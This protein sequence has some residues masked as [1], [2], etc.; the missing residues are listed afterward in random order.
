MAQGALEAQ[1][2]QEGGEAQGAQLPWL[3]YSSPAAGD[4]A[5]S[6]LGG[7]GGQGTVGLGG[8][9][10]VQLTRPGPWLGLGPA[11]DLA[12]EREPASAHGPWVGPEA[13][14]GPGAVGGRGAQPRSPDSGSGA[15]TVPEP[16]VRSPA[17]F[18]SS[19]H[20][21]PSPR[22]VVP[23]PP[24]A[25]SAPHA[26][27]APPV[28]GAGAGRGSGAALPIPHSLTTPQRLLPP[29]APPAWQ[30]QGRAGYLLAPAALP[31]EGWPRGVHLVMPSQ[32]NGG[33]QAGY[34]YGYGCGRPQTLPVPAAVG[35]PRAVRVV[36]APPA[37]SVPAPALN[38]TPVG[39]E[40][41][42]D[43]LLELCM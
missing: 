31:Q 9:G 13:G 21:S 6:S 29:Q 38:P 43:E 35:P 20:G 11:S 22:V 3:G 16:W 8:G 1:G 36:N 14:V 28:L 25:P 19:T 39:K 42:V 12:Q 34:D 30:E 2:A 23:S 15:G 24:Y 37:P 32:R 27:Y 33:Q 7:Q 26:P 4:S 10:A 41:V 5:E 40:Q 18:G 17:F